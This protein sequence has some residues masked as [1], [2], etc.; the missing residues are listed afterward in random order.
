MPR[1]MLQIFHTRKSRQNA[2]CERPRGVHLIICTGPELRWGSRAGT[3]GTLARAPHAKSAVAV[4]VGLALQRGAAVAA[5]IRW[6]GT[7]GVLVTGETIIAGNELAAVRVRPRRSHAAAAAAGARIALVARD[8]FAGSVGSAAP[9]CSAAVWGF[10]AQRRWGRRILALHAVTS[11]ANLG[12]VAHTGAAGA[13]G[14]V[15][16]AAAARGEV[17]HE[18]GWDRTSIR[19]P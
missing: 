9:S 8:R 12:D 17:T 16:V 6:S 7:A 13:G 2:G 11:W 5:R 4:A 14:A 3:E 10:R 1:P 19:T 18:V 15:L